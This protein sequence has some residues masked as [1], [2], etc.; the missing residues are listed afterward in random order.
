MDAC[1]R[2]CF[3]FLRVV[4]VDENEIKKYL[5]FLLI[6]SKKINSVPGDGQYHGCPF[7]HNQRNLLDKVKNW[8]IKNDTKA[9][10]IV[11][12]AKD[13]KY[14]HA[15]ACF[16]DSHH[17]IEDTGMLFSLSIFSIFKKKN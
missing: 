13:G 17:D 15:C 14:Q 5:W 11:Q 4:L 12:I 3:Q 8:G 16:F 6:N 2:K 7:K 9:K 1:Q 10:K